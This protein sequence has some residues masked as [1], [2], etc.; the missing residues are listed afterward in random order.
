LLPEE[1][2]SSALAQTHATASDALEAVT[3][4]ADAAFIVHIRVSDSGAL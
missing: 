4:D 1:A 2:P 3:F